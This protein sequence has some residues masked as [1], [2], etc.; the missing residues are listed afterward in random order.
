MLTSANGKTVVMTGGLVLL[1]TFV[2][3]VGEL[4]RARLVSVKLLTG[5]MTVSVKFVTCNAASVPRFQTTLPPRFVPPAV[6]FEN[7]T[8]LGSASVTVTLL[9]DDGPRFVT[10]RL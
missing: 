3:P 7:V 1:K 10:K 5:A 6:A 4:T 9:A 8:P 2:S